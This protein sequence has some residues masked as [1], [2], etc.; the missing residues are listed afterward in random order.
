MGR[1][2]TDLL[3]RTVPRLLLNLARASI[4]RVLRLHL[5]LVR[6]RLCRPA[7]ALSCI[8]RGIACILAGRFCVPSC[9]FY[10]LSSSLCSGANHSGRHQRQ[11]GRKMNKKTFHIT[12][13]CTPG[14][15]VP[16]PTFRA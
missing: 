7:H 10:I 8:L 3:S 6:R 2:E 12:C 13:E 14:A 16:D 5:G 11:R 1:L 9:L 4:H 15:S